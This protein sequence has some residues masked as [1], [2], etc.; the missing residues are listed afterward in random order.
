MNTLEDRI[1]RNKNGLY[2]C[3]AALAAFMHFYKLGSIPFGL[4]IDEAGMAY[5]AFCLA[6]YSVD[7]YLNHFPVYLINYGGG[8]SALYAYM[9]ALLIRL[10][11]EVNPWIIRLPGALVGML[12]YFSGVMIVRKCMGEKW[13]LLSSMF[14][15]IFPYFIMQARFGLDCNLLLGISTF[16]LWLLLIAEEKKKSLWF[17][18]AGVVWGICYYTY[19]LGYLGNTLFLGVL[20][21]YWLYHK[22]ITWKWAFCFGIPILLMVWPLVLMLVIN[23]LGLE[24]LAIGPVTIPRLPQYRGGELSLSN[25]WEHFWTAWEVI[26]T[27]DGLSYNALDN[28]YT[29]YRISIPF[30][31]AGAVRMTVDMMKDIIYRWYAGYHPLVILLYAWILMGMITGG[32][33]PNINR[34]N[35]IFFALLFCV[36][37]G[38]RY[39]WNALKNWLYGKPPRENSLKEALLSWKNPERKIGWII[40]ALYIGCFVSYAQYYFCKYP[41]DIYPQDFFADTCKE[42]TDFIEIGTGE[43]KV[44]YMD[45]SYIYYLLGAEEDP[46]EANLTETKPETYWKYVFHL[47][48]E[49]GTDSIYIVRET[50]E[51]YKARLQEYPFEVYHSGMYDCYYMADEAK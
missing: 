34:L 36:L 29:M 14:L 20:L 1:L 48:E 42:I 13:G 39:L 17:I 19:A 12:G 38:M 6:N 18:L 8:Q 11:G 5:D 44:V 22:R 4:H 23:S 50:N 49:I 43:P 16:G 41:Q 30:A 35:G 32:S 40:L 15:A 46:Y 51:A 45:A 33:G 37:Y 27:Q 7:R 10:T 28:F 9:A 31:V 3:M 21:L 47:P 24:E 26:L 2:L 25:M